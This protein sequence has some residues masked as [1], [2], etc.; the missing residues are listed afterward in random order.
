MT[1]LFNTHTLTITRT[2]ANTGYIDEDGNYVDGT[3]SNFDINC[4]IQPFR[5]G[6]TEM[7][8]PE[9]VRSED[10]RVIYTKTQLLNNIEQLNQEADTTVIDGLQYECH[11]VA[12]WIGYQ[13]RAAENYKV[14]FVRVD[15]GRNPVS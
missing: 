6:D 2:Q 4:N 5:K 10:V 13:L 3:T 9:G 7:E 15:K 14:M 11:N 12:T 8:L 1:R